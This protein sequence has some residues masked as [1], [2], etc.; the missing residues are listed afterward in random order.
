MID[1]AES[2]EAFLAAT[3][4]ERRADREAA[5]VFAGVCANDRGD[6]L[7]DAAACLN[8]TIGGWRSQTRGWPP[9]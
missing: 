4:A 8:M 9:L 7:R 3:A 5:M 1:Q 2:V 6:L